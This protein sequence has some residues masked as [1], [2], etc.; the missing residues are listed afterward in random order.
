MHN[1]TYKI[2]LA[3]FLGATFAS[4]AKPLSIKDTQFVPSV[5]VGLGVHR[6]GDHRGYENFAAGDIAVEYH[7]ILSD[8]F[9]LGFGGGFVGDL[10]D[11]EA[12]NSYW[13]IKAVDARYRF[14][15]QF[16]IGAFAGGS[17]SN[18]FNKAYGM[19]LGGYIR[20]DLSDTWSL[21]AEYR[22]TSNDTDNNLGYPEGEFNIRDYDLLQLRLSYN[23]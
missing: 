8:K 1:I 19:L 13:Y 7:G 16:H 22:E 11:F 3:V 6:I 10:T 21:S 12:Q 9:E 17:Y 4:N 18:R 14:Y 20:Y 15:E 5:H 23:F 2:G